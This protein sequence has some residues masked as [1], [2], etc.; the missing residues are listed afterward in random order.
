MV[1]RNGM[2]NYWDTLAIPQLTRE[3]VLGLVRID[4]WEHV[5]AARQAGR[6]V[7]LAG[8]HLSSVALAGQ[9][10]A[11]R[12]LPVVG[13]VEPI[14]PPEVFDFFNSF[15]EAFGVRLFAVGG[16]ALREMLL[17]LRRNEVVGLVTDRDVLGTGPVVD[18]FDAPTT[19]PDGAAVLS[20]RTGAPVLPAVAVRLDDGSFRGIVEGPVRF[21]PTGDHH[22]DVRRLTQAVAQRLEYHIGTY[23]LQW[24]VFQMR[25]PEAG[26]QPEQRETRA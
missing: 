5:D 23:P 8:A 9:T 6:G 19:F 25:W 7:I 12:G 18:F 4:G 2:L 22:A 20:L 13:V 14:D 26:T 17:A 3:E 1:F 11:A 24:T 10:V 16:G 21:E 15:R